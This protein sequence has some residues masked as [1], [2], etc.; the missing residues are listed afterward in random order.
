MNTDG[1]IKDRYSE[2]KEKNKIMNRFSLNKSERESLIDHDDDHYIQNSK[3]QLTN[4]NDVTFRQS[5]M[6]KSSLIFSMTDRT[7]LLIPTNPT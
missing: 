6:K 2:L 5:G 3:H 1:T 7:D 4:P